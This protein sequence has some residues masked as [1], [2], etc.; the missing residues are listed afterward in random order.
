MIISTSIM[1][2]ILK[3]LKRFW[4]KERCIREYD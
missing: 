2:V 3:S 4:K 1:A